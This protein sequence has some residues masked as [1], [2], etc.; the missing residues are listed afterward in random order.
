[1]HHPQEQ[2]LNMNDSTSQKGANPSRQTEQGKQTGSEHSHKS[3]DRTF[4][5]PDNPPSRQSSLKT[6]STQSSGTGKQQ[7]GGPNKP[8]A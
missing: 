4:T 8:T 7:T 1:L 6:E 5:E 2:Q 3:G